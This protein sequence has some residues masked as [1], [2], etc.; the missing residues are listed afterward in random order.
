MSLKQPGPHMRIKT[1]AVGAIA[2]AT[3]PATT[4]A[5]NGHVSHGYGTISAG[6]AGT[7]SA[8]SQDSMAAATNLAV[9]AFVGS[10]IDGGLEVFS[11]RRRYTV[12]GGAPNTPQ[13]FYLAPDS[14]S[15]EN[16]AFFIP[17]FGYTRDLD[18]GHSLGLSI[19][20][21]GGMNT[22]YSGNNGGTYGGGKT[23]VNL[24][25]VFIAP[26]WSWEFSTLKGRL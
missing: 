5:T 23:G 16:K 15:S 13:T 7:G 18:I 21:N 8:L 19:F 4:F 10:R 2:L 6:L 26:T 12:D 9:M 11:S 24:E 14:V 3:L 25:Q 1:P 17:H 20:A 22:E